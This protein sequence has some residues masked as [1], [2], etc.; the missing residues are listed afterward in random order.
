MLISFHDVYK[1]ALF[2]CAIEGND[3]LRFS[4]F[5]PSKNSTTSSM[6]V[7]SY[8]PELTNVQGRCFILLNYN[9]ASNCC[10]I[11]FKPYE[12]AARWMINIFLTL[13]CCTTIIRLRHLFIFQ[14]YLQCSGFP[15]AS[16]LSHYLT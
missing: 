14:W 6:A 9:A 2:L 3:W 16:Q 8:I 12:C 15:S 1:N 5:Y 11:T 7:V 4:K 10:F 13:N